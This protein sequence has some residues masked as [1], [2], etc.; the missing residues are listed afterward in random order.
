M[1]DEYRGAARL[2]G[3]VRH[4]NALDE[5][6]RGQR[7]RSMALNGIQGKLMGPL[8]SNVLLQSDAELYRV[9]MVKSRQRLIR[10]RG[11]PSEDKPA[12]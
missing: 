1:V 6:T 9:S 7:I 4:W 5:R 12:R 11:T 10:F 8:S 3:P 2:R